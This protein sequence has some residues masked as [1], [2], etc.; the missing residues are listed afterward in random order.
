MHM[1]E[2]GRGCV[3]ITPPSTLSVSSTCLMIQTCSRAQGS[4]CVLLLSP[5]H[6][7]TFHRKPQWQRW[8]PPDQRG[9]PDVSR[10]PWLQLGSWNQGCFLNQRNKQSRI[11]T[12]EKQHSLTPKTHWRHYSS[13]FSTCKLHH[14]SVSSSSEPRISRS[15]QPDP[16]PDPA[17]VLT[18]VCFFKDSN[19]H[20][21]LSYQHQHQCLL[22][23]ISFPTDSLSTRAPLL[24]KNFISI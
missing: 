4:I 13:F 2:W 18:L 3:V 14:F 10:L 1:S 17:R 21:T 15:Q 19:I 23:L 20:K 5:V 11:M 24:N 8:N 6:S 9:T 7:S 12:D 22:F 16:S